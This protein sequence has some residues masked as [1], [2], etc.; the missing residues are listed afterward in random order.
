MRLLGI[1]SL[2]HQASKLGHLERRLSLILIIQPIKESIQLLNVSTLLFLLLFSLY[3]LELLLLAGKHAVPLKLLVKFLEQLLLQLVRVGLRLVN[4][5]RDLLEQVADGGT[6]LYPSECASR[7]E[8]RVRSVI[9]SQRCRTG[10]L[11]LQQRAILLIQQIC[12]SGLLLQLDLHFI[13][14]TLELFIVLLDGVQ[15]ADHSLKL[16]VEYL[17]TLHLLLLLQLEVHHLLLDLLKD[18][19]LVYDLIVGVVLLV[20]HPALIRMRLPALLKRLHLI[21]EHEL[22]AIGV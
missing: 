1:L 16:A 18:A 3:L 10:R 20:Q 19:G 14:L 2:L 5:R 21:L 15:L 17:N 8:V 12:C 4:A 22:A 9:W 7:V 6:I 11:M 13:L